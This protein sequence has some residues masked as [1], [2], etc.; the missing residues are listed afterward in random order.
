MRCLQPLSFGK[1]ASN[2]LNQWPFFAYMISMVVTYSVQ[3]N[4]RLRET[5]IAL[6]CHSPSFIVDLV[7]DLKYRI[8]RFLQIILLVFRVGVIL[9]AIVV[10]YYLYIVNAGAIHGWNSFTSSITAFQGGLLSLELIRTNTSLLNFCTSCIPR[11]VVEKDYFPF[12]MKD[13]L[14]IE[15]NPFDSCQKIKDILQ[16]KGRRANGRTAGTAKDRSKEEGNQR[17]YR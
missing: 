11:G 5:V 15:D 10:T 12:S 17:H 3:E 1:I 2:I 9:A 16:A 6:H 4:Y 13:L 14:D 7:C 8:T